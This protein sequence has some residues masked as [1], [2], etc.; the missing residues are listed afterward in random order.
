MK[1]QKTV[2]KAVNKTKSDNGSQNGDYATSVVK[3]ISILGYIGAG[4]GI[5]GG[6]IFLFGGQFL[7]A[8]MPL[9]QLP[10]IMGALAGALI[11][12]F[13]ILLIAF[14]IFWIF[15]SKALWNHKN[16][17]RIVYIVFSS[18]GVV[19]SLLSMPSGILPLLIDG[20]IIYFLAF[21]DN[22]KKL[23]R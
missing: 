23:F 19:N 15:V 3:V 4:F 10:D 18:I 5:L 22:V 1:K 7:I 12:V 21:D 2:K 14:S 8:M 16:W 6:L 9:E 20:G 17:A 11:T 13:S